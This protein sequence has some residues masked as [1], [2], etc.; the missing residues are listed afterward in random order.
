MS[1][2]YARLSTHAALFNKAAYWDKRKTGWKLITSREKSDLYLKL[3][4]AGSGR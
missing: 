4:K 1:F 2:I 3:R